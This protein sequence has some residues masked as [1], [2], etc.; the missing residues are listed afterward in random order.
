MR[1][2]GDGDFYDLDSPVESGMTFVIA[3]ELV[4]ASTHGTAKG[5]AILSYLG[6]PVTSDDLPLN[7][8]VTETS[9]TVTELD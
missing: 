7:I 6:E 8:D 3:L 5:I 1:L 2:S 4:P 9:C